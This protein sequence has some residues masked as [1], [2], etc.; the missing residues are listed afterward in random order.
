MGDFHLIF[1]LYFIDFLKN[2]GHILQ[3]GKKGLLFKKRKNGG[4]NQYLKF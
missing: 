3:L 2:H 4:E 1:L